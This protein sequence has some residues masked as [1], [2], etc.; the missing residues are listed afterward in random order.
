MHI[1]GDNPT[2]APQR[3]AMTQGTVD[4][5][6]PVLQRIAGDLL[7]LAMRYAQENEARFSSDGAREFDRAVTNQYRVAFIIAT[8]QPRT[9][10]Q[11]TRGWQA[12]GAANN[13]FRRES[14]ARR[15]HGDVW[16]ANVV[17]AASRLWTQAAPVV[18]AVAAAAET[19]VSSLG[20][21]LLVL[22]A[23]IALV[24]FKKG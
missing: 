4:A 18:D 11:L 22:G 23:G 2:P 9:E 24:V 3:T 12:I 5:A 8:T 7:Q 15:T 17:N 19:V 1:I 10:A 13:A 20:A 14:E 6:Y 21:G 16:S